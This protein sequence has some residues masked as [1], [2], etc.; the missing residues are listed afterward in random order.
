MARGLGARVTLL[1]VRVV[2][3]PEPLVPAFAYPVFGE[4]VELAESCEMPVTICIVHARDWKSVC[5]QS[6]EPGA[7]V[8]MA[9]RKC[10]RRT[11]E[12]RLAQCLL[13]TG[14][15]VTLLPA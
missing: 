11:R 5:E 1:V 12:E 9:S 3:F 4:L 10:W 15:K 7:L 8:V 6:V 14:H 13:R 2:P